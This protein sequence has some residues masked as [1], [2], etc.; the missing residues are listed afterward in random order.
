MTEINVRLTLNTTR[1]K[2]LM[3]KIAFHKCTSDFTKSPTSRIHCNTLD[4]LI[5]QVIGWLARWLTDWPGDWLIGQ[6]TDWLARWLT[7]WPGDW[8]IGQVIGWLARWLAD[9]PGDVPS[10]VQVQ[11]LH[12]NLRPPSMKTM[13]GHMYALQRL[14]RTGPIWPRS[15]TGR[16]SCNC[17]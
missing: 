5:G 13:K 1:V 3:H 4:R 17:K 14:H 6:V 7:D 15:T 12:W 10:V 11:K 2:R 16:G 9:W 8:L